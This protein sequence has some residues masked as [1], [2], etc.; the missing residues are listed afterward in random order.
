MNFLINYSYS[1]MDRPMRVSVPKL[2]ATR[3]PITMLPVNLANAL[4]RHLQ[5]VKTQH[6]QDLEEGFGEVYLPHALARK[7]PM[8][9]A[10][11]VGSMF[12]RQ[13]G[14][15]PTRVQSQTMGRR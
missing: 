11:G 12:F 8:H 7:F 14:S 4:E 10:N 3:N 2:L 15:R 1:T 5:K 9:R 6:E 13:R